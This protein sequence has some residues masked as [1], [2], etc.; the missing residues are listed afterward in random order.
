LNFQKNTQIFSKIRAVVDAINPILKLTTVDNIDIDLCVVHVRPVQPKLY[1][2]ISSQILANSITQTQTSNFWYSFLFEKLTKSD[3]FVVFNQFSDLQ[4]LNGCRDAEFFLESLRG[5]DQSQFVTLSHFITYWAKKRG[6]YNNALGYLGGYSWRLLLIYALLQ[7]KKEVTNV[8][9]FLTKFF[10][11]VSGNSDEIVIALTQES[12]DQFCKHIERKTQKQKDAGFQNSAKKL[13]IIT[14]SPTYQNSA[15]NITRSTLQR[16]QTEM[17]RASQCCNDF[18]GLCQ[19]FK[20]FTSYTNYLRVTMESN[21]Q[22]YF[23]KW[24]GYVMSRLVGLFERFE[25]IHKELVVVACPKEY[26]TTD[27]TA[28]V[29]IGIRIDL[30]Q[31]S[32]KQKI[33]TEMQNV[34]NEFIQGVYE[35]IDLVEVKKRSKAIINKDELERSFDLSIKFIKNNKLPQD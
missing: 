3:G 9:Q 22:N 32:E 30:T 15:R 6:I 4:L 27:L 21:N 14:P 13:L 1:Q 12:R 24:K 8:E 23:L 31:T 29:Y 25:Q 20:F 11:T 33:G 16:I 7:E 18:A 2:Q 26:D 28:S 5:I 10:S 17:E 34:I 19:P 35:Q